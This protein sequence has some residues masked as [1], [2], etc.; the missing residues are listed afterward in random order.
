MQRCTAQKLAIA[1]VL[2]ETHDHPSAMVICERVR[3]IIPNISLATVYRNLEA[4]IA[5]GTINAI[6]GA[7]ECRFDA[8]TSPH[9]HFLCRRCNTMRDVPADGAGVFLTYP[10]VIDGCDVTAARLLFSGCCPACRADSGIV[11]S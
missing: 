8:D 1:L 5:T 7:P 11:L 10:G 4:M 3:G 9:H 2:R 6:T